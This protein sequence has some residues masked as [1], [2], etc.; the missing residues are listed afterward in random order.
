[1]QKTKEARLD[2]IKIQEIEQ[3][4]SSIPGDLEKA[5][6]SSGKAYLNMG[7]K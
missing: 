4:S 2:I 3:V 1:L 7:E 5:E 6:Q